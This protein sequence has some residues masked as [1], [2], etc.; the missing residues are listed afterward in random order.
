MGRGLRTAIFV[1]SVMNS[2]SAAVSAYITASTANASHPSR[3]PESV[4]SSR[5][6]PIAAARQYLAWE[7]GL[8]HQLDAQ[9]RGVF[10]IAG[11][12]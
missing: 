4:V 11:G 12:R 1:I 8:L 6:Y 5:A 10:R 7:T 3:Y 9:E 2:V